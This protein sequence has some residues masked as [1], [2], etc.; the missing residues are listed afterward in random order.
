MHLNLVIWRIWEERSSI[1]ATTTTMYSKGITSFKA[2]EPMSHYISRKN[3]YLKKIEHYFAHKINMVVLTLLEV[4][5][6]H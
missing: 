2:I 5:L 1:W 6:V 4:D 3:L